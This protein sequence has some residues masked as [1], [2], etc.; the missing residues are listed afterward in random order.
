MK[1]I[2]ATYILLACLYA[3]WKQAQ[4]LIAEMQSE[5]LIDL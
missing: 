2:T 3:G 4:K 5:S 1:T